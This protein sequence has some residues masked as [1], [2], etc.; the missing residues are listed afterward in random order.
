MQSPY[1]NPGFLC[2]VKLAVRG[3][4]RGMIKYGAYSKDLG[5]FQEFWF[6]F[7]K[8]LV[9]C[10]TDYKGFM[11]GSKK[12]INR[13]CLL[14]SGKKGTVENSSRS[15]V[16]ASMEAQQPKTSEEVTSKEGLKS[17]EGNHPGK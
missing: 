13:S 17:G 6:Q 2:P 12:D 16:R 1:G 14:L 8:Y 11:F 7:I 5:K 4:S 3:Y 15:S 9:L 10:T